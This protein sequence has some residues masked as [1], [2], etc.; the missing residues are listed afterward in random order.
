LIDDK[1][2]LW[3]PTQDLRQSRYKRLES[4][5]GNLR[6]FAQRV[7]AKSY[8]TKKIGSRKNKTKSD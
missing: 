5:S 8:T 6:G 4:S 2:G 1:I 3:V 7:F